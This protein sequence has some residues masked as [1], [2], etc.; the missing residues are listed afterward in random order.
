MLVTSSL[1]TTAAFKGGRQLQGLEIGRYPI[2]G[3]PISFCF[4]S[5]LRQWLRPIRSA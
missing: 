4:G 2:Y 5:M 1:L 3:R